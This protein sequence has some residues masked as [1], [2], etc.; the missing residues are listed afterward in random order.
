MRPIPYFASMLVALACGITS[1]WADEPATS[2]KDLH[3]EAQELAKDPAT[4]A[5]AREKLKA[6]IAI[7]RENAEVY[8]QVIVELFQQY[9]EDDQGDES[10]R[11]ALET[12]EFESSR[13]QRKS[14]ARSLEAAKR[15]FPEEFA[16]L[17]ASSKKGSPQRQIL[18]PGSVDSGLAQNILQRDDKD[19]REKALAQLRQD[20]A[21]GGDV[22]EY[23]VALH[24]LYGALPAKFDRRPFRPLVLPLLQSDEAEVRGWALRVLPGL[25]ENPEDLAAIVPLVSDPDPSVRGSVARALIGI[26]KGK[27]VDLV[28]PALLKL[29]RD[30]DQKV[31]R[32]SIRSMWGEYHTPELNEELIKLSND[33]QHHQIAIYHGLSTQR[34]KSVVVCQRLIEE[35]SDPDWNNSGRAAWGLTYGVVPEAAP[36]VEEGLLEALP[37]ETNSYTRGQELRAL[38]TVATKKSRP[39]LEKA[40]D[41]EL[42]TGEIRAQA[43]AILDK[44]PRQ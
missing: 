22:R 41:S 25:S 35:L 16:K 30:A 3:R 14:I 26:G 40:A 2:L 36:L 8:E 21:P 1:V 38:S 7:H 23:V 37:E 24:N 28:A 4:L 5:Q 32:E 29:L 43:K 20:L 31:V 13:F 27:A 42:E 39:F 34:E 12:A 18:D 9:A 10:A 19:L 6:I 15:K 33:P 17:A 44:I 11:L